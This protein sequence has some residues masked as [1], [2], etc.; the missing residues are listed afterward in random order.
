M[1][2]PVKRRVPV[3]VSLIT[4]FGMLFGTMA[5]LAPPDFLNNSE[6]FDMCL[7]LMSLFPFG[8]AILMGGP[9]SRFMGLTL[10]V[11]SYVSFLAFLVAFIRART[12][13]AYGMLCLGFAILLLLNVAGCREVHKGLSKITMK[14]I[15]QW[16]PINSRNSQ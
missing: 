6:R 2:E 3:F 11:I 4:Y 9:G 14:P 8:I 16:Y 5:I 15:E 1:S 7:Q 13:A 12:W 10:V